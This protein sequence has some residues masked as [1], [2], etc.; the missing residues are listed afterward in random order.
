MAI[1]KPAPVIG[2]STERQAAAAF[3]CDNSGIGGE[4]EKL[5]AIEQP[6]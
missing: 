3:C 1:P 2:A 4:C 5:S 6:E